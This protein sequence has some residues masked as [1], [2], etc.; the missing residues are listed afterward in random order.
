[1]IVKP[2]ERTWNY[3]MGEMPSKLT[4]ASVKA[5]K[6]TE[7]PLDTVEKYPDDVD[8]TS[9]ALLLLPNDVEKVND[10]LDDILKNVNAD[11]I[12][13]VRIRCCLEFVVN[14]PPE[15]YARQ[16]YFDDTRP[17]VDSAV[18]INALRLFYKMDR[19]S[20]PALQPTKDWILDVL[21]YRAY[22]DGTYYYPSGDIFLYLFSRLLT[23]N[24]FSDIYRNA[25]SLLRERLKERIGASGDA[26][27]LA[28]RIIACHDMGVPNI[29]DSRRL[30]TCQMEDGGWQIGWLCNTG[31]T[32]LKIG[33]RGLTTALSIK[34]IDM[35][36]KNFSKMSG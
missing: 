27:E 15:A 11:G 32:G 13:M 6:W 10:I 24:Q 35:V 1:M 22:L 34:A 8:T 23:E 2:F 18:C 26:L 28:M 19:G 3:F 12:I 9:M 25:A 21:F 5:H 20:S 31:K 16:T 14:P 33:N 30:Q 36:R 17:R 4:L 7:Y 29:I